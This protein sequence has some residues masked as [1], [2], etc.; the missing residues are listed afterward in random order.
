MSSKLST[1]EK[2]NR[3]NLNL[4][5]KSL[6]ANTLRAFIVTNHLN[7]VSDDLSTWIG[8]VF[9]FL[10]DINKEDIDY[11]KIIEWATK[12]STSDEEIYEFFQELED[13]YGEF[14]D[15]TYYWE[16]TNYF[17]A[18]WLLSGARPNDIPSFIEQE[19]TRFGSDNPINDEWRKVHFSEIRQISDNLVVL[20]KY[21]NDK[22]NLF[23]YNG[24]FLN[25]E[26]I[27]CVESEDKSFWSDEI[28]IQLGDNNLVLL[29][30]EGGGE[31]MFYLV[32]WTGDDFKFIEKL[33]EDSDIPKK[34][35]HND[36]TKV[37]EL[38]QLFSKV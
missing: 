25:E 2:F 9:I 27:Y 30:A 22:D 16:K 11:E 8:D 20:H 33:E 34:Y 28:S 1:Q 18:N 7:E 19:F 17:E 26:L 32:E 14:I 5:V 38:T 35:Y 31:Y 37:E 10:N 21:L 3:L 23:D 24:R 12:K 15:Y 4:K 29:A 36:Y 6:D 13:Q